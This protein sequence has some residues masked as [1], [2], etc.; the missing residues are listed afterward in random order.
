M[1]AIVHNLVYDILKEDKNARLSAKNEPQEY[2]NIDSEISGKQMYELDKLILDYS[3]KGWHKRAF[4]SEH[5]NIY[6]I[7]SLNYTNHIHYQGVNNIFEC[8]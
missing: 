4:E 5:E 1:N 6:Y 3:H 7:I 8:N 2:D